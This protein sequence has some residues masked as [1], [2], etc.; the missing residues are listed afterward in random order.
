MYPLAEPDGDGEEE[1]SR[2]RLPQWS[3]HRVH[4][5]GLRVEDEEGVL[6]TVAVTARVRCRQ[7]EVA[8]DQ[9]TWQVEDGDQDRHAR[10]DPAIDALG[11]PARGEREREVDQLE[12]DKTTCDPTGAVQDRVVGLRERGQEPSEP[13]CD[14]QQPEAL[15]R[16]PGPRVAAD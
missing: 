11:D 6:W 4:E 15:V 13:R 9:P 5:R 2:Q 16:P 7:G 14:Q 12:L 8:V 10:D 3:H 1:E